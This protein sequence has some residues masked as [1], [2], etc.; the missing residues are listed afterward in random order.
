[1][2][3]ST[4]IHD[5][6]LQEVKLHQRVFFKYRKNPY[7][8]IQAVVWPLEVEMS[9][10][11]VGTLMQREFFWGGI[12]PKRLQCRNKLNEQITFFFVAHKKIKIKTDL[13]STI[14][15]FRVQGVFFGVCLFEC[16][17]YHLYKL[18]CIICVFQSFKYKFAL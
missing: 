4:E 2:R 9:S 3:Y 13:Q 12:F 18:V 10:I 8:G 1:M 16:F 6:P 15:D 11:Y 5:S 14:D 17:F 7:A